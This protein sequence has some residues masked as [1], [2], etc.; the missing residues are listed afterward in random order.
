MTIVHTS[1]VKRLASFYNHVM[2]VDLTQLRSSINDYADAFEADGQR[3][4]ETV[5]SLSRVLKPDANVDALL[6]SCLAATRVSGLRWNGALF[7]C[8]EAPNA[9][10]EI[11][12]KGDEPLRYALIATDG[13]QIMPD[14]HKAV[15][16]AYVQAGCACITYGGKD[17]TLQNRVQRLKRARLFHERELFDDSGEMITPG[18]I[19]NQRDLLEIELM[20]EAALMARDAG[21]LPVIIADGS[22]VPFALLGSRGLRSAAQQRMLEAFKRAML[23]L[24]MSGALA[25]GYI[26]KPNSNALVNTCA[27]HD[28]PFDRVDEQALKDARIRCAGIFD[29]H[30]LNEHLQPG[31]RTG[32]F[33]PR[34]EVNEPAHLGPHAM[35]CCYVNVGLGMGRR[36]A[37]G[38]MEA[39]AWCA[40]PANIAILSAI[41]LRQA[42]MGDNYPLILKVAHEE[43]VVG[44]DDQRE[45]E[46]ALA[47]VLINRG[48]TPY[49]SFKSSAK[50]RG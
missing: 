48:I 23:D 40:T 6:A 15:L 34:W 50:E 4:L 10:T 24:Q 12:V 29:R 43:A 35:R 18:E 7:D 39:P 45:I 8:D 9:F 44:K 17:V 3:R 21:Y 27:L 38:R 14:R 49:P 41:L 22:M 46:N 1:C 31:H 37:L 13:S 30:V 11:N 28:V 2:P 20:A 25:C 36:V 42:R 19:S 5:D 16:F 32:L 26:D 47:Q 33:D